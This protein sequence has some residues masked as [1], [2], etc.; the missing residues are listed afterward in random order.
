[1]SLDVTVLVI[2]SLVLC[3]IDL[4]LVLLSCTF[5]DELYNLDKVQHHVKVI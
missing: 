3:K 2:V 1:M 4:S 5:L